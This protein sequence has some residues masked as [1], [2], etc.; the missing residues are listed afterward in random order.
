[1]SHV[2]AVNV[3]GPTEPYIVEY[4]FITTIKGGGGGG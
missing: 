3:S 1:M 4:D 2:E